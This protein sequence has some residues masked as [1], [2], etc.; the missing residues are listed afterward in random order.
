MLIESS[1]TENYLE[2]VWLPSIRGL[3]SSNYSLVES[4]SEK[5]LLESRGNGCRLLNNGLNTV[6]SLAH[7]GR[8]SVDAN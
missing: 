6:E 5:D 7:S 8:M 3:V 4:G 2:P 1:Y